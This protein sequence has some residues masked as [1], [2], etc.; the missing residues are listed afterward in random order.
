MQNL[1]SNTYV[2]WCEMQEEYYLFPKS[3]P[4]ENQICFW[5]QQ[6]QKIAR[7]NAPEKVTE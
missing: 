1:I 5:S 3:R 2:S 7:S 4:V 6:Q